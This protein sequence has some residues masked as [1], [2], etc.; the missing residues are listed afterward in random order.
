MRNLMRRE[1]NRQLKSFERATMLDGRANG[2]VVAQCTEE[3]RS[4][5]RRDLKR[6]E[7]EMRGVRRV[8]AD[9]I[10][11]TQKNRLQNVARGANQ[12]IHSYRRF[13]ALPLDDRQCGP[14]A[15]RSA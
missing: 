8:R 14:V 9:G 3:R 12:A 10:A 4:I 11:F 2:V 7:I 15:E 5:A 13:C 6:G 1:G